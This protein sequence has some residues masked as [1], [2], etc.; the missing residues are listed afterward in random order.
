MMESG[1]NVVSQEILGRRV[2][3]PDILVGPHDDCLRKPPSPVLSYLTG[4]NRN[5]KLEEAGTEFEKKK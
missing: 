5:S 1:Q 2:G 4:L 3:R